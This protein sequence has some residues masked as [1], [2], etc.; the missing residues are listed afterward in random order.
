MVNTNIH[1]VCNLATRFV[2]E[3]L[4]CESDKLLVF[5]RSC[6]SVCVIVCY[7]HSQILSVQIK[8]RAVEM[9]PSILMRLPNRHKLNEQET[10]MIE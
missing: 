10:V 5:S 9:K 7:F 2:Y 6:A 1:S 4:F 8:S 3:S